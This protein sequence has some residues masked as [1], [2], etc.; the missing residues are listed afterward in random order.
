MRANPTLIGAFVIG[1]VALAVAAVLIFGSGEALARK[2][3]FILY[4]REPVQGLVPGSPVT[5][6][7][8]RVGEVEEVLLEY[9]EQN[10]EFRTPVTIVVFSN[11]FSGV[12]VD[13]RTDQD[14]IDLIRRMVKKGYRAT[15]VSESLITGR[16]GI[17]FD[18]H[19]DREAVFVGGDDPPYPELP[20]TTAGLRAFM[21][22]VEN[23]PLSEVFEDIR[24]AFRVG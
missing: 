20:T 10:D 2:E 9:V 13:R 19:P 4:F 11:R 8:V 23:L 16:L 14:D 1:G 21:K 24:R 15:L 18:L 17:A 7:G 22:E 5:M 12:D 3:R 6:F